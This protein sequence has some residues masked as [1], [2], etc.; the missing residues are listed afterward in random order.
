MSVPKVG[1][2][3]DVVAKGEVA[4]ADSTRSDDFRWR[5]GGW[6]CGKR[7]RGLMGRC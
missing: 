5:G 2:V 6:E 3:D 7:W 4:I 1:I